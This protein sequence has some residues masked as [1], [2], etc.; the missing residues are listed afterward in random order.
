MPPQRGAH[1]ITLMMP[2]LPVGYPLLGT[3]ISADLHQFAQFRA[4]DNIEF[5]YVTLEQ[6]RT[7]QHKQNAHLYQLSL[8]LNNS[9]NKK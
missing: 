1:S 2:K 7:A 9:N 4:A 5:E 6:A 8:A 3:V